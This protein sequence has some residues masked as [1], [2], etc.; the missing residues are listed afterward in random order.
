MLW[1][2]EF[3]EVLYLSLE[4]ESGQRSDAVSHFSGACTQ[5]ATDFF[6]WLVAAA[7]SQ[8]LH[9]TCNQKKTSSLIT[10]YYISSYHHLKHGEQQHQQ[11]SHRPK[12]TKARCHPHNNRIQTAKYL[13]LHRIQKQWWKRYVRR[14]KKYLSNLAAN[15]QDRKDAGIDWFLPAECSCQ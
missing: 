5:H 9:S 2:C 13:F 12:P 11:H 3:I 7:V 8:Q 4:G 1:I 6:F 15:D 10:T 14:I